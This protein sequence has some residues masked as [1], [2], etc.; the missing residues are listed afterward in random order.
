MLTSL[1]TFA[2]LTPLLFEGSVSAQFL[3]PMATSLGFGVVFAT[4]ISLFLVPGAYLILEDLSRWLR[5][6]R[7]GPELV[8]APL[9]G[10][11][12]VP[13]ELASLAGKRAGR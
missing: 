7:R 3:I 5:R 2:G 1:T 12:E 8:R 10:S 13:R 6:K 9:E 11:E 4:V